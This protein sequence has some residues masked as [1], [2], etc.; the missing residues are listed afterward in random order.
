M[1]TWP[2]TGMDAR[3]S[4][5]SLLPH[6]IAFLL[7]LHCGFRTRGRQCWEEQDKVILRRQDLLSRKHTVNMLRKLMG[8]WVGGHTA[9]HSHE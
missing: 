8:F 1:C 2:A 5:A 9:K 6:S 7:L 3:V 4:L